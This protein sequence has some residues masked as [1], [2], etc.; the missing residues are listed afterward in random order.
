[1]SENLVYA[2]KINYQLYNQLNNVKYENKLFWFI[3][4]VWKL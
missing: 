2:T 1:M 3:L 4:W